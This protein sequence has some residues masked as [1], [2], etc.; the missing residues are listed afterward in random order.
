M[1]N[2][3]QSAGNCIK[4]ESEMKKISNAGGRSAAPP[5]RPASRVS[6][7]LRPYRVPPPLFFQFYHW[8]YSRGHESPRSIDNMNMLHGEIASCVKQLIVE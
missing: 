6:T 4:F 8:I 7:G 1:L 5:R 2:S 3:S